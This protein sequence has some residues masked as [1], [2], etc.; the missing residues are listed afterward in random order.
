MKE[1]RHP[2]YTNRAIHT[3]QHG[4]NNKNQPTQKV[5]WHTIEFSNIIRT[6]QQKLT[7]R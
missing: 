6:P 7:K 5:H 1:K 2:A 4:Q 3:A